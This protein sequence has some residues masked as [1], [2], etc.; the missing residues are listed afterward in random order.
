MTA[1]E[2]RQ[3]VLK[4]AD[5]TLL[6][7]FGDSVFID[8]IIMQA[9]NDVLVR[10]LAV[11]NYSAGDFVFRQITLS[12]PSPFDGYD[13]GRATGL[14]VWDC[15]MRYPAPAA[16]VDDYPLFFESAYVRKPVHRRLVYLSPE[17]FVAANSI[18]SGGTLKREPSFTL[19]GQQVYCSGVSGG[20]YQWQRIPTTGNPVS[21]NMTYLVALPRQFYEDPGL[22]IVVRYWR[23]VRFPGPGS[24][25]E[26]PEYLHAKVLH[27]AVQLASINHWLSPYIGLQA[28]GGVDVLTRGKSD[29]SSDTAR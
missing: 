9:C 16:V 11:G 1:A 17:H 4:L 12:G 24:L 20:V 3:S 2:L 15:V 22:E 25:I 7:L 29:A 5:V 19:V 10:E 23:E 8:Q 6:E 26:L 28:S 27:R 14:P 18:P 13:G 21:E